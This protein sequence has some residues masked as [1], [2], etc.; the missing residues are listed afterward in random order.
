MPVWHV[1]PDPQG[2]QARRDDV[3][4]N[5][6]PSLIMPTAFGAAAGAATKSP[7]GL[8]LAAGA[9]QRMGTPKALVGDWLTRGVDVLI[10]AGC[11]AGISRV[12][13]PGVRSG[14]GSAGRRALSGG[15][16]L[17]VR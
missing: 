17:C 6:E 3:N 1:L 12:W 8:L 14:P 4:R 7:A 10:A 16:V 11:R 2:D 13:K 9:G 5:S 15:G